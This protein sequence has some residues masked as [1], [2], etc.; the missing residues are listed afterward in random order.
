MV[1]VFIGVFSLLLLIIAFAGIGFGVAV[2]SESMHHSGTGFLAA[3]TVAVL[4]FMIGVIALG[5]FTIVITVESTRDDTTAL[6]RELLAHYKQDR[7]QHAP[8]PSA[9]PEAVAPPRG[10]AIAADEHV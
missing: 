1:K 3:V 6:L 8:A 4:P 10:T 5:A 2:V 9:S 7:P